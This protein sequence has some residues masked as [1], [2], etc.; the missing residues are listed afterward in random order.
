MGLGGS[1]C[2]GVRVVWVARGKGA[3]EEHSVERQFEEEEEKGMEYS[4][5]EGKVRGLTHCS[6]LDSME[7]GWLVLGGR[8]M[9][10]N[11]VWQI[12]F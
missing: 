6:C 3:V 7:E 10:H 9:V 2:T 11:V 4:C 12:R 5:E 8:R 1:W